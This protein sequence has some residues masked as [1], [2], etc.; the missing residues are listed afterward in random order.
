MKM[1]VAEN[2][3]VKSKSSVVIKRFLFFFLVSFSERGKAVWFLS[4]V[5]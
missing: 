4:E 1:I 3:G 5:K 2:F